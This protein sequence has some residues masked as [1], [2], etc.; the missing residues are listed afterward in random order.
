MAAGI[1]TL[2]LRFPGRRLVVGGTP[3]AGTLPAM[4]LPAAERTTQVPPTCVAG[5][6]EKANPAVRAA[7]DAALKLGMGLQEPSPARSD[8]AGQ[9]AW[10]DRPDANPRET[11]KTSRWR[12]Q[13]SQTLGYNPQCSY[14]HPRPTSST[15]MLREAG[16]GFFVPRDKTQDRQPES[17]PPAAYRSLKPFCL[18]S[19]RSSLPVRSQNALLGRRNPLLLSK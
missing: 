19:R 16:R 3:L 4:V 5:M 10:R 12:W 11:R 8:I 1:E 18:P 13:K 9:A 15:R 2:L 6:R 14:T 17:T 7:S